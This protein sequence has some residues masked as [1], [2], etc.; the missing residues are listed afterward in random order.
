MGGDL[1]SL[2]GSLIPFEVF[3]LGPDHRTD[4]T[5]EVYAW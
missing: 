2:M 3:S 4:V 1:F 5:K